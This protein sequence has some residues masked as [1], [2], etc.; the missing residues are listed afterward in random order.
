ML[1]SAIINACDWQKR[2]EIVGLSLKI[3][4]KGSKLQP[5]I[6]SNKNP[7]QSTIKLEE[8][9]VKTQNQEEIP[10]SM[11]IAQKEYHNSG[12]KYKKNVT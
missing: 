3:L 2:K 6:N 9:E 4:T 7:L 8:R 12:L 10:P 5:L 11:L 1:P